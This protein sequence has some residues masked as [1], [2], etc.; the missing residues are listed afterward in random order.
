MSVWMQKHLP[1]AA[2]GDRVAYVSVAGSYLRG[3][4]SGSASERFVHRIYRDICGD[5]DVWGDGVV[6]VSSAL[7]PGSQTITLPG[8]SHYTILGSRWYGSPEVLSLWWN[9]VG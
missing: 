4:R 7:L 6:P 9:S 8:V 2:F 5:G 3:D 1:G